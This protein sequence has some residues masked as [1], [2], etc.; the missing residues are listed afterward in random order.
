[1]GE[2]VNPYSGLVFAQHCVWNCA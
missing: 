2:N 1:M